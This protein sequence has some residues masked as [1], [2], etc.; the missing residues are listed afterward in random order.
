M[1]VEQVPN[2]LS[3]VVKDQP[4]VDEL[5]RISEVLSH[6]ESTGPP[7]GLVLP[8]TDTVMIV[9]V[10]QKR[11]EQKET[12]L[13]FKFSFFPFGRKMT[14]LMSR[15]A[16]NRPTFGRTLGAQLLLPH[17]PNSLS[18]LLVEGLQLPLPA[19]KERLQTLLDPAPLDPRGRSFMSRNVRRP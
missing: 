8:V 15:P 2:S 5:C 11:F 12:I 16:A 7:T 9:W 19:A 3:D 17:H 18:I 10:L 13:V 4:P 1:H 6:G 14:T